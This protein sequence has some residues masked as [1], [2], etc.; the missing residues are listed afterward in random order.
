MDITRTAKELTEWE[1]K[2]EM[3]KSSTRGSTKNES[4]KLE[5]EM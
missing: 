2:I 5:R 3:A 4:L 1:T